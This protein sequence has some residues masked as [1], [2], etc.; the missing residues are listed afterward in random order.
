MTTALVL[1]GTV[2]TT[3]P[4]SSAHAAAAKA[5]Y[6][7]TVAIT[8]WQFPA[9][10]NMGG[11]QAASVADFEVVGALADSYLGL[12]SKGN[13]YA[14]MVTQVPSTANGGIKEV[15]GNEVVTYNLRPNMK[16]SDGQAITHADMVAPLLLDLAPEVNQ[17][18]PYARIKSIV[19][20]GDN[21]AITYSGLYAPALSYGQ[22]GLPNVTTPVPV[23]YFQAK[24]GGTFPSDLLSNYTYAAVSAYFSGSSYKGSSFQKLINAWLSDS[25]ISPKDVFNGPY[26]LGDW[27]SGQRITLVP[28][29]NYN[30]LPADP[31][32]P[33]V[34]KI[35]FVEVS[36]SE[37]ALTQ[38]LQASDT[39]NSLDKAEDFQLTDLA[40]LYKSKYNVTLSP[41]LSYEHLEINEAAP[42]N[43]ALKDVRVRQAIYYAINK[44]AYLNAEFPA[45]KDWKQIALTSP[46][47]AVSPWSINGQ[48][49]LN[50]FDKAKAQSL[51][52]AAGYANSP[53]SSGNHLSLTFTTSNN[54][55]RIRSAQ[56]L[57]RI[58]GQVGIN[59]KIRYVPAYGSNG[60][61]LF[62]SYQDGGILSRHFFD[63][64][65]FAFTTSPDPDQA[66]QNF[67]P[68]QI[69]SAASPNGVNYIQV[70]DPKLVQFFM[71]ARVTLDNAK[72]QADYSSYQNYMIQQAYNISLYNRPNIIAFKG[73]IGNFKPNSTQAG[74]EWN[75][76]EW[77]YDSTGGQKA[78]SS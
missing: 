12:N 22:P 13:F 75:A 29:P 37:A 77:W 14:D 27:T 63:I 43:P 64:T 23:H 21:M 78:L 9:E 48:L 52:A 31:N 15:S 71:D 20:T 17:V 33:R 60:N 35:Q 58:W 47:P 3:L 56:L 39:Y 40:S 6:A 10:T 68:S 46:L 24:Y 69:G 45:V 66:V 26:M 30:I 62:D 76:F 49:P 51:L 7:G 8:D 19:F 18:D 4:V 57:Q 44:Q 41:A 28:N 11:N 38:A 42:G 59:I 34:A 55:T 2:A 70:R 74:N 73:T 36:S 61:G 50:P 16:W 72:R 53:G 67:L 25:Y 5:S 1:L 32:H 54:A 65:E